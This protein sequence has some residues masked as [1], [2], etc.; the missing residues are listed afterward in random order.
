[1]CVKCTV[2][3]S[4]G[5][6]LCLDNVITTLKFH[7]F[8]PK[9]SLSVKPFQLHS[10]TKNGECNA[11]YRTHTYSIHIRL[12]SWLILSY[13]VTYNYACIATSCMYMCH[14][15]II[16]VDYFFIVQSCKHRP[17]T[18]CKIIITQRC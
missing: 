7:N 5:R 16:I 10:T 1:M 15:L 8:V 13:W 9:H 4:G 12:D 17:F 18:S 11:I 2:I 6:L 14:F 3:Y